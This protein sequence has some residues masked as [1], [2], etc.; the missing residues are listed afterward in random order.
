MAGRTIEGRPV[1]RGTCSG[2]DDPPYYTNRKGSRILA[3]EKESDGLGA[4]RSRRIARRENA[5]LEFEPDPVCLGHVEEFDEFAPDAVDF[6]DVFLRAC[7]KLDAIN[8][9]AQ[10]DDCAADLIALI[11]FLT[12][13]GHSKP[14]PTLIEQRRIVLHRK[15]PLASVRI[16][17]ILPHRLDTRLEQMV[18]RIAL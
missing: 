3:K 17:L 6:L 5:Y 18:V 9:R 11:E 2:A 15:H 8:L 10:A 16:R 13:K 14:L 1:S 12:H 4:F 7:P